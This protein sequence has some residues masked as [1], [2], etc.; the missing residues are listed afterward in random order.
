VKLHSLRLRLLAGAGLWILVALLLAGLA[1]VSIFAATV[2]RDQHEDLLAGLDQVLSSI[3][4]NAPLAD[5]TPRLN[6]PRYTTP[7]GG[8]YWQVVDLDTG[9]LGQ[10]RSLWD[11]EVRAPEPPQAGA[12]VFAHVPGPQGQ[13]LGILTQDVQLEANA[14]PRRLRASIA[15][16]LGLRGRDLRRFATDIATALLAV[17]AAL[18]LAAW[19]Q[20]YLGLRPLRALQRAVE[21]VVQGRS[22]RLDGPYPAEVS[23]VV[24]EVN[25]LL[26][27]HERAIQFA[28]T[29][30]DDLAHGLKT[31]LAVLTAT[32]GRLRAEGDTGNAEVLELL[33]EEMAERIDYQL[34]LA[35]LRMRSAEHVLTASLDQVLLR[36]V[37]VMR[38]AGRGPELFWKLDVAPASVDMDPHDLMELV[39]VLLENA[40]KWARSQVE[41]ICRPDGEMAEFIIRDDGPGL[42]DEDIAR[43][44][45][46]GGRLDEERSGTGFGISIAREVLELNGGTLSIGR[47]EAGGLE[48]TVRIPSAPAS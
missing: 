45:K 26:L 40:G 4:P 15:E 31:P 32:A 35:Q 21:D 25:A 28:R 41:V 34:R 48:A 30:A 11:T 12:A 19:L 36:S 17:G 9:E 16:D 38:K 42:S 33:S 23:P 5:L 24:H 46:R 13:T 2:E 43:L 22:K 10:S 20:V 29:R 8:L 39:G 47:S 18:V 27:S 6:D 3:E 1:I 7:A 44:G 14:G 37:T